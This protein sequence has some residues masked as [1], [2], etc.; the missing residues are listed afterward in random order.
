MIAWHI[1]TFLQGR[2]VSSMRVCHM[3]RRYIC[4][5]RDIPTRYAVLLAMLVMGLSLV[6]PVQA[7]S[8]SWV[9]T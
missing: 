4:Q 5:R 1:V 3:H 6:V 2:S 7:Q 8:P 9:S